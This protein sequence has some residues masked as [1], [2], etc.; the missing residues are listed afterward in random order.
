MLLTNRSGSKAYIVIGVLYVILLLLLLYLLLYNILIFYFYFYLVLMLYV[1]LT[2]DVVY[3]WI[4]K[5]ELSGDIGSISVTILS[6]LAIL[7]CGIAFDLCYAWKDRVITGVYFI[8]FYYIFILFTLL[9]VMLLLLFI[10]LL[11]LLLL[12]LILLLTLGFCLFLAF[13]LRL[14]LKWKPGILLI[15]VILLLVFA[16][17]YYYYYSVILWNVCSKWLL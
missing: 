13:I 7:Y 10:L 8:L 1:T 9:P 2:D 15:G 3:Y 11:I 4:F 14:E 12:L 5:L 16:F 6:S 17:D